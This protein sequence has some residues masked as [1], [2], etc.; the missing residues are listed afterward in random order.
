MSPPCATR[1]PSVMLEESHLIVPSQQSP[2]GRTYSLPELPNLHAHIPTRHQF[3]EYVPPRVLSDYNVPS[4]LR[5]EHPPSPTNLFDLPRITG[6]WAVDAQATHE[7][8]LRT[9]KT[10]RESSLDTLTPADCP[11]ISVPPTRRHHLTYRRKSV[12]ARGDSHPYPPAKNVT[13]L[14]SRKRRKAQ[15]TPK[16]ASTA[17]KKSLSLACH[18]CRGRNIACSA[19]PPR[20]K[21]RTCK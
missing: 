9:L 17:E 2:V 7:R 11:V 4:S 8:L 13:H 12:V 6:C 14:G 1:A 10:R 18:S 3:L 21:D 20:S 5:S 16:T 15:Y 19:P